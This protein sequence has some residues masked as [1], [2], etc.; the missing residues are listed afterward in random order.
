[1]K[2]LEAWAAWVLASLS[3]EHLLRSE[4][5]CAV[6]ETVAFRRFLL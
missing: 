6:S 1:M 5:S 2:M 3:L 4:T